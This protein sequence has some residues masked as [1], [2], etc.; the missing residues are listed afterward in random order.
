MDGKGLLRWKHTRKATWSALLLLFLL[1]V[2]VYG[3]GLLSQTWGNAGM[4]VLV[5]ALVTWPQRLSEKSDYSRF[6]PSWSG[7]GNLLRHFSDILSGTL[8]EEAR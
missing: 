6:S 8:P 1:A 7:Q 2:I 4:V 5:R 3:P